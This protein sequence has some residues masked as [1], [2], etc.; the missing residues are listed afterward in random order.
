MKLLNKPFYQYFEDV[1]WGIIALAAMA[2]L[3]FA[4]KPLG[5][6]Y[7]TGSHLASMTVLLPVLMVLYS[8]RAGRE[9]W[10][11]RDI[12]GIAAAL[13]LINWLLIMGAIALDESLGLQTYFTDPE[14][15]GSLDTATHMA[16]HTISSLV[17]TLILWGM[18]CL[19]RRFADQ[20]K[21][22]K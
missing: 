12:L 3:R 19:L 15:V 13:G 17:F 6:P 9:S 22:T 21:P 16:G 4:L 7:G 20:G 11:D 1:R 18:G 8:V 5:V 14:H 2:L 10:G